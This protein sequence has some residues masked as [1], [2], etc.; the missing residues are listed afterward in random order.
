MDAPVVKKQI[1]NQVINERASYG[2]FNLKDFIHAPDGSKVIFRAELVSGEALP[3][4][5]ICTADGILTGIPAKNTQGNH[6]IIVTGENEA[7]SIQ[8]KFVFTIKPSLFE[9]NDVYFEKLKTQVW[10]ALENNLPIP[11]LGALLDRPITPIEINYI[12]ERWAIIIVWDAFN[13]DPPGEKRPLFLEGASDKYNV[14]DRGSCIVAAPKDLFSYDRTLLDSLQTAKAVAQEVFKRNW[15]IEM[16]GYFKL[17]RVAWIEI[18][19]LNDQ[20]GKHLEVINYTPTPNEVSLYT[21]QAIEKIDL[22]KGPERS[23]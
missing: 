11:E 8:S 16:A 14:Y 5:L 20:Y 1:P 2:P 15:T 18:Q 9:N 7:G 6:E 19:H 17:T 10:E 12:L 4:G 3:K 21:S 13:L 22:Q 23:D